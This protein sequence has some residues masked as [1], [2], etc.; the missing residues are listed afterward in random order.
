VLAVEAELI[1]ARA[2]PRGSA[3]DRCRETSGRRSGAFPGSTG[4]TSW[5]RTAAW[6]SV[7]LGPGGRRRAARRGARPAARAVSPRAISL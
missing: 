7:P 4:S 1:E 2:R 6:R 5:P 3:C